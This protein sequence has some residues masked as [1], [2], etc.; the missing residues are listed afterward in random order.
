[1]KFD[2][3][4]DYSINIFMNICSYFRIY[5]YSNGIKLCRYSIHCSSM[6]LFGWGNDW[7]N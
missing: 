2:M 6:E 5:K 1:V 7:H 4:I 3:L